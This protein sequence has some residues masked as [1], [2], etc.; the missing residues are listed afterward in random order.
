MGAKWTEERHAKVKAAWEE[1][2]RR[3]RFTPSP[4]SKS[5]EEA[6]EARSLVDRI[7]W[8]LARSLAD[9]IED[10]A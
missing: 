2:R 8:D 4:L 3:R 1:K 7:G 6:L 10:R 5:I 9:R